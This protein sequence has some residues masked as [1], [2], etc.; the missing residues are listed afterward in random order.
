MKAKTRRE[1]GK[2]VTK[3]GEK[4]GGREQGR[5]QKGSKRAKEMNESIVKEGEEV[6]MDKEMKA[7]KKG[8]ANM[9]QVL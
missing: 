2:R 3:R 6:K 9:I 4:E 1:R 7:K 5:K 8:N